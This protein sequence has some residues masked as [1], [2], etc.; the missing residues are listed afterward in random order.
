MRPASPRRCAPFIRKRT[1]KL[2]YPFAEFG[3]SDGIREPCVLP[4]Q[5]CLAA[6]AAAAFPAYLLRGHRDDLAIMLSPGR[7]ARAKTYLAQ[8]LG[9]NACRN[10]FSVQ[11]VRL[12]TLLA[13]FVPALPQGTYDRGWRSRSIRR[14]RGSA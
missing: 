10:G 8:A 12:P 1:K 7:A 2:P 9:L 14:L 6:R 13:Q 3:R 11:Y 4:E 5:H